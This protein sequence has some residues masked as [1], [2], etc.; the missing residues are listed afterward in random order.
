MNRQHPR[1]LLRVE[2]YLDESWESYLLRMNQH[3]YPHSPRMLFTL[4]KEWCDKTGISDSW[5]LPQHEESY[6][7]LSHL[8]WLTP[9]AML[10][11]TMHRYAQITPAY[12]TELDAVLLDDKPYPLL[13]R[14]DT[15]HYVSTRFCPHCL[16]EAAY[17][18]QH[19][20]LRASLFCLK[21]QCLLLDCCP[22]CLATV[23]VRDVCANQC[24]CGAWLSD[25]ETIDVFLDEVG[26]RVQQQLF[27]WLHDQPESSLAGQVHLTTRASYSFVHHM[28]EM[29]VERSHKSFQHRVRGIKIERKS[30]HFALWKQHRAWTVAFSL[31]LDFPQRF[32]K[33]LRRYRP[34]F[35]K[36]TSKPTRI[37]QDIGR[38]SRYAQQEWMHPDFD[39]IREA[40]EAFFIQHYATSYVVRQSDFY[41]K[42]PDLQERFPFLTY[43]EAGELLDLKPKML[44]PM[45]YLAH[46]RRIKSRD[47]SHYLFER[48]SVEACDSN[49]SHV[50][51]LEAL[52]VIL[53]CSMGQVEQLLAVGFLVTERSLS[54]DAISVRYPLA[55]LTA[56]LYQCRHN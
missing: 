36:R 16:A 6:Q 19:W 52:P 55:L 4:Y 29:L 54:A 42:R 17:H 56:I 5:L 40:F 9:Q 44:T 34:S 30:V 7:W 41:K 45:T 15:Q 14:L 13:P 21:H 1:L 22:T 8:V 27:A 47:S 26:R 53:G 23:S 46:L 31:L 28:G 50:V 20:S 18:R 51:T 10:E 11:K 12:G 43:R 38:V 39:T 32:H 33:F 25:A 35:S 48:Q 24:A 2:T 37:V 49:W 3:N